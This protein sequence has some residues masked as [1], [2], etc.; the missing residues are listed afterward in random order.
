MNPAST[1]AT[2]WRVIE[3]SMARFKRNW[4]CPRCG[5][6]RLYLSSGWLV[7]PNGHGRLVP[8]GPIEKTDRLNGIKVRSFAGMADA[9]KLFAQDWR[10][11]EQRR[12]GVD[13]Q[14]A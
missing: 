10:D 3:D 13:Q 14:E 12:A 7:C 6:E 4:S 9:V 2:S 11:E 5:A 1:P 8:P